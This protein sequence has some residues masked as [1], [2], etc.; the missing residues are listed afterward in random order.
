MLLGLEG[1]TL[2]EKLLGL[3]G[4]EYSPKGSGGAFC[5]GPGVKLV[6]K[7]YNLQNLIFSPHSL[8]V[9][10]IKLQDILHK[11]LAF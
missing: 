8:L 2:Y 9:L 1:A 6:I 7:I 5:G 3:T 11:P 10:S 4:D